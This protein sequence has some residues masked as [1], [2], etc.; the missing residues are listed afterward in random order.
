MR[1]TLC[2]LIILGL[3]A[4]CFTLNC[5]NCDLQTCRDPGP[6]PRGKSSDL[7]N[8]C[9]VCLRGVGEQCG[10]PMSIFG[11]CLDHL[12][13]VQLSGELDDPTHASNA[14]GI[15]LALP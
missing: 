2:L 3:I 10:G 7:C 5:L 9:P 4:S 14:I 12:S 13:C 1:E 11:K 8:C 6:C 15:C